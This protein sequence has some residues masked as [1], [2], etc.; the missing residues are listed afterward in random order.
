[1]PFVPSPVL[2]RSRLRRPRTRVLLCKAPA[3]GASK[4]RE[5]RVRFP[6][7]RA[8]KFQHPI[9]AQMAQMMGLLG[10]L[11][12]ALRAVLRTVEQALVLENMSRG[13]LVS[14]SQLPRLHKALREACQL[15][16]ME[17]VPALYVRQESTPNA[18]TLAVPGRRAFI[19]VH[20]A[21]LELLD[22]AEM[23]AVLAHELGHLKCEHGV[24]VLAANVFLALVPSALADVLRSRLLRWQRAAELS[25]DRAA[26]LVMQEPRVVMS[27]LMKLSGGTP[28]YA[29]EL[30]L[31]SFVRQADLFDKES[32]SRFGRAIRDAMVTSATHPLPIVRV[33]ELERWSESTQFRSLMRSGI[34]VIN[35]KA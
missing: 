8:N 18:Y 21:L 1:M 32:A 28:K 7:L 3:I 16:D 6:R 29:K 22:E 10:V 25:C 14:E 24:W 31:D 15:L 35:K 5:M 19:V 33:K 9:D 13:V 12:P 26:L 4:Q 27:S 30:D 17:D 34:P 23:Q 20:T 2:P 11:D